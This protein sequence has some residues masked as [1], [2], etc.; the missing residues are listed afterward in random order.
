MSKGIKTQSVSDETTTFG[1][2]WD[3]YVELHVKP[4]V[5][6][7]RRMGFIGDHLLKFFAKMNV[8]DIKTKQVLQYG[9]CRRN[10]VIGRKAVDSTIR[11]EL[12]A[13]VAAINFC[14]YM[15]RSLPVS[16]V[17]YIPLP[18]AAPPKDVW[19]KQEELEDF[20]AKIRKLHD[21]DNLPLSR[22]YRFVM[23]ASQTAARRSAIADLKWDQVDLENRIIKFNPAGRVQTIKRR[24]VVPISKTLL[25]V[26]QRAYEER[27]TEYVLDHPGDV[28]K[29]FQRAA[30]AVG[31]P[32]VTPHVL[33]HTWATHAAIAGVDT[34]KIAGVL[35]D[36]EA[37][38]RKNYMHYNPAY[39][40]DAVDR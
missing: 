18:K 15:H 19:L 27:V 1:E 12:N 14:A 25:P 31:Y 35:G 23:I 21:N 22:I 2:V 8:R 7:K 40:R 26:L 34:W 13:M 29:L 10:G 37:T 38:V 6:T 17:P 16:D 9:N 30:E 39:L 3:T 24:P 33:R 28:A 36:N 5:V 32:H 20:V 11:R 4:F